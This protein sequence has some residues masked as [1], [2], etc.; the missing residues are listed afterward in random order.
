[1]TEP[2]DVQAIRERAERVRPLDDDYFA[3]RQ[4]ARDVLALLAD[5]AALEREI[6]LAKE[7]IR[8]REE[9]QIPVIP[10]GAQAKIDRLEADRAALLEAAKAAK[11]QAAAPDYDEE[12]IRASLWA[13]VDLTIARPSSEDTAG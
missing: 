3:E 11:S 13:L 8:I 6:A 7:E 9:S 12:A 1:M 10:R 2:V 5:R 4:L